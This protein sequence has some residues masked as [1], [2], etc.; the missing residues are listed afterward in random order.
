MFAPSVVPLCYLQWAGRG[1]EVR[2]LP[3]PFRERL[4]P[5]NYAP[6]D[7]CELRNAGD[8]SRGVIAATRCKTVATMSAA[9]NSWAV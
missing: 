1:H 3:A 9:M 7:S 4:A 5:T 2:P 6:D 8:P